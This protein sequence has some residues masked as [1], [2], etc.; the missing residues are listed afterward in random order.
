MINYIYKS[1]FK[2]IYS[3]TLSSATVA[4]IL[5][6]L[7]IAGEL[8]LLEKEGNWVYIKPQFDGSVFYYGL[9]LT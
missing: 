3:V 4:R 5:T 2:R 6:K 7:T 1:K 8:K 9:T